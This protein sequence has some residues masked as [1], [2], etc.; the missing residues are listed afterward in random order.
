[1]NRKGNEA[2]IKPEYN[3]ILIRRSP[4][5]YHHKEDVRSNIIAG[6]SGGIRLCRE[7]SRVDLKGVIWVLV[8]SRYR[9]NVE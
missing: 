1:M 2:Y 3:P 9:M 5:L 4:V 6:S 8:N 7:M